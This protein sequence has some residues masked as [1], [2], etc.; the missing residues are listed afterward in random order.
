M[1]ERLLKRFADLVWENDDKLL[2]SRQEPAISAMAVSDNAIFLG[3]SIVGPESDRIY[4]EGRAEMPHRLRVL[5][6]ESGELIRDYPLPAQTV[7][8]GVAL[9]HGRVYVTTEDGSITAFAAP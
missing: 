5:D 9:A 2:R 6:L 8:G 7:Q 1:Q 4:R 3:L